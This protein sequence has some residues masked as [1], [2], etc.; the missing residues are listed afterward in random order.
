MPGSVLPDRACVTGAGEQR[1]TAA[2]S[3]SLRWLW[4]MRCMHHHHLFVHMFNAC[5]PIIICALLTHRDAAQRPSSCRGLAPCLGFAWL[6]VLRAAPPSSSQRLNTCPHCQAP[7]SDCPPTVCSSCA[8]RV[9]PPPPPHPVP[10]NDTDT[11]VSF[12]IEFIHILATH[13]LYQTSRSCPGATH[14]VCRGA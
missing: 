12:H 1:A 2:F 4:V 8:S 11:F 10:L 13:N 14:M 9:G 6:V 5:S 3:R 7:A